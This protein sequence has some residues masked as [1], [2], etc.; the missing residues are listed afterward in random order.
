MT[1]RERFIAYV[2]RYALTT[3]IWTGEVEL[4]TGVS[5]S[6]VSV[7]GAKWQYYSRGDWHR[8]E[9]EAKARAEEMRQAKIKSVKKQ[10]A[11]LE[12]LKF[13]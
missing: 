12:A 7:V 4:C 1:G 8:T 13:V 10:L 2:T 9:V 6:M 3:G 11:R 5:D